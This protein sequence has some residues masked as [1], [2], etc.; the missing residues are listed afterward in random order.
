MPTI[1]PLATHTFAIHSVRCFSRSFPKQK[2]EITFAGFSPEKQVCNSVKCILDIT[3]LNYR[4]LVRDKRMRISFNLIYW[5]YSA[6]HI[7]GF[8]FYLI[9]RTQI[10]GRHTILNPFY[11]L[12][13][14][15]SKN[16]L[17][18]KPVGL[19]NRGKELRGFHLLSRQ[20]QSK[21][22]TWH[23]SDSTTCQYTTSSKFLTS[24]SINFLLLRE[25]ENDAS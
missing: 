10:G 24:L 11:H 4:K 6:N 15:K 7:S 12:K 9:A 13:S 20:Q 2:A 18:K 1:H 22:A 8:R 16:L 17:Q 5:A 23:E 19:K 14:H 25:T 3:I 21:I